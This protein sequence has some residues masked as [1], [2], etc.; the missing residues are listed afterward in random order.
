M[1]GL[2]FWV[3]LLVTLF[4]GSYTKVRKMWSVYNIY[5]Q[6]Q[7]QSKTVIVLR[8]QQAS[9]TLTSQTN[10][11]SAHKTFIQL[12]LGKSQKSLCL[13]HKTALHA[14][15]EDDISLAAPGAHSLPG[16]QDTCMAPVPRAGPDAMCPLLMDRG[17]LFPHQGHRLYIQFC[18]HKAFFI[19]FFSFHCQPILLPPSL[20]VFLQISVF[21]T[22]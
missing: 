5:L 15:A 12:I 14:D 4:T 1:K 8:W 6:S 10:R 21:A 19:S 7:Q 11:K 2:Y 20:S 13:P 3:Y 18:H 9:G 16:G 17:E 22:I